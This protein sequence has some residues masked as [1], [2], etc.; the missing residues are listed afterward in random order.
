MDS[1]KLGRPI[2]RRLGIAIVGLHVLVNV[3]HGAS[4]SAMYISMGPWQNAYIL[5]VIVLLPI[6]SGFLLWRRAR[7]SFFWLFVS[8]IGSLIFG[9]YYHFIAA[10]PD[11]VASLGHHAWT[12]SFQVS[13]VL[14]ALTEAAGSAVG[15][16]GLLARRPEG[17]L[18]P[19]EH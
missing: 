5:S 11:N 8:M 15:F 3:V 9:V 18:G 6:V 10:G 19:P 13:A 4:H 12:L 17:T 1:M 7:T 14:L 2:L 16:I